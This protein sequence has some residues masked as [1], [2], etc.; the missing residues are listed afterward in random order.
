MKDKDVSKVFWLSRRSPKQK[1]HEKMFY[2]MVFWDK[3]P[4]EKKWW[5]IDDM[6]PRIFKALFGK[7]FLRKG[8]KGPFHLITHERLEELLELETAMIED[9][10]NR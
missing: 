6:S 1:E 2:E 8:Q 5:P 9:R 4:D 7:L 10:R 3:A